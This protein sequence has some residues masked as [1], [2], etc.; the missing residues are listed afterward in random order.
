[1]L[2]LFSPVN[3]AESRTA[4]R[5][6][7]ISTP[8]QRTAVWLNLIGTRHDPAE[9][10]DPACTSRTLAGTMTGRPTRTHPPDPASGDCLDAS[11]VAPPVGCAAALF[12]PTRGFTPPARP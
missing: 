12:F 6:T 4:A 2:G 5:A 1:M 3:R 7:F 11:S 9:S 10:P 8:S